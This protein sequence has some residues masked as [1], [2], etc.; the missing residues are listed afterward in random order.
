MHDSRIPGNAGLKDQLLALRWVHDNIHKFGGDP[1]NVT[2]A[3]QSAG[4]VSATVLDVSDKT[5]GKVY[6]KNFSL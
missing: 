1:N 3:G 4:S 5:K 6:I 2:I